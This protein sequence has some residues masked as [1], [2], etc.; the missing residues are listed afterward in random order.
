MPWFGKRLPWGDRYDAFALPV[1]LAVF[2]LVGFLLAGSTHKSVA[3]W[4]VSFGI[5]TG[6]MN[7]T[8]F[9]LRRVNGVE[10]RSLLSHRERRAHKA[11]S[12]SGEDRN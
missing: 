6:V 10:N 2:L 5:G 11:S 1:G 12:N 4:L 7:V 8:S 9:I 3:A